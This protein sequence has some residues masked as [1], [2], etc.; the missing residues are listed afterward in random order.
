MLKKFIKKSLQFSPIITLPIVTIASSC[1]GEKKEITEFNK[2]FNT[3][4]SDINKNINLKKVIE[5]KN[6]INN[7]DNKTSQDFFINT[8]KPSVLDLVNSRHN[9]VDKNILNGYIDFLGYLVTEFNKANNSQLEIETVSYEKTVD[10][11]K[12]ENLNQD[13]KEFINAKKEKQ[14]EK[15]N[16]ITD[17]KIISEYWQTIKNGINENLIYFLLKNNN[18]LDK[19]KNISIW[20]YLL[21]HKDVSL[22]QNTANTFKNY[23]SWYPTFENLSTEEKNL[24]IN[25]LSYFS[26]NTL[27]NNEIIST[28]IQKN[29][30]TKNDK[31]FIEITADFYV[32]NNQTPQLEQTQT[33]IKI[34]KNPQTN[35]KV[36]VLDLTTENL[37]KE[38]LNLPNNHYLS[39]DQFKYLY[40]SNLEINKPVDDDY[41]TYPE[42]LFS[43]KTPD[44]LAKELAN[45][46]SGSEINIGILPAIYY[47]DVEVKM[48]PKK[49]YKVTRK[50]VIP[51]KADL[52]NLNIVVNWS[53]NSFSNIDKII[54]SANVMNLTNFALSVSNN[55]L[56][57][58]DNSLFN[59]FGLKENLINQLKQFYKK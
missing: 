8:F 42:V 56:D 45:R 55:S 53:L 17:K 39:F 18:V 54:Q 33:E 37:P 27:N 51:Y 35:K 13:T 47:P 43:G 50:Y 46:L 49:I 25:K 22:E 1:E 20:N 11:A 4:I 2:E 38:N 19:H 16:T 24:L 48:L 23:L 28:N 40:N 31:K 7:F 5:L 58:I 21:T 26:I 10:V 52:E 32:L 30:I 41:T 59:N 3:N 14:I 36:L 57:V 12:E 29:I 34:V 9:N 44:Q 15:L 6:Q